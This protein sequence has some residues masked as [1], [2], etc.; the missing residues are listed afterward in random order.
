MNR[1]LA[2]RVL[3]T[4]RF[5]VINTIKPAVTKSN[6]VVTARPFTVTGFPDYDEA[7]RKN[8]TERELKGGLH[9]D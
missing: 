6:S 2:V 4:R 5:D 1:F 3:N 8:R 9:H 7:V